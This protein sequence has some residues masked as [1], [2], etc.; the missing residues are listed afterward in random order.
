MVQCEGTEG[1][2]GHGDPSAE[3]LDTHLHYGHLHYT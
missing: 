1:V 3:E 2:K